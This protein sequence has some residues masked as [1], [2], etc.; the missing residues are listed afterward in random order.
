M[1]IL[2]VGWR[3]VELRRHCRIG[4]KVN[5]V[6][7]VGMIGAVVGLTLALPVFAAP[8]AANG[9]TLF[10]QRCQICHSV[11]ATGAA[12]VGPNLKGVAGRK[13]AATTFTY[14][15]ALKKSNLIWTQPNL[16]KYL[17]GPAALVP[18]TRMV[19]KLTDPAQRAAV[20]QYLMRLR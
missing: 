18:G 19:I 6:K 12:G 15:P 5:G 1:K 20:I 4:I 3:G 16:D 7:V 8:P 10:R 13:A 17:A 2:G 9:E 11:A 14:S